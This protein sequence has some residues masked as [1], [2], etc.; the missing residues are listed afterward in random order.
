MRYK[1]L[2]ILTF[3]CIWLTGSFLTSTLGDLLVGGWEMLNK[4]AVTRNFYFATLEYPVSTVFFVLALALIRLGRRKPFDPQTLA[5]RFQAAGILV[6]LL[7]AVPLFLIARYSWG[8]HDF[9]TA[10][11]IGP[12]HFVIGVA[13][14]TLSGLVGCI[15]GARAA[16]LVSTRMNRQSNWLAWTIIVSVGVVFASV[17]SYAKWLEFHGE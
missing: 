10:K 5:R 17:F 6:G 9:E 12:V 3:A 14:E 2:S 4:W 1:C 8:G 11:A 13:C 16:A 7:E 15:A